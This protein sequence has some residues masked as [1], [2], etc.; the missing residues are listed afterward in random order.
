MVIGIDGHRQGGVAPA[1]DEAFPS[2]A[3][4]R[5]KAVGN[6][7]TT[8]VVDEVLYGVSQEPP[9][10]DDHPRDIRRD[11]VDTS[12][13]LVDS[14]SRR[15]S[16]VHQAPMDI[17]RDDADW[18]R[19]FAELAAAVDPE[20]SNAGVAAEVVAQC[21]RVP[22]GM[23]KLIKVLVGAAARRLVDAGPRRPETVRSHLVDAAIHADIAW[24]AT[25]G[26]LA[27]CPSWA[28]HR[29][30]TPERVILTELRRYLPRTAA[31]PAEAASLSLPEPVAELLV[32]LLD[33]G[34][35]PSAAQRRVVE[36]V[37]GRLHRVK[38]D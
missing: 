37:R 28:D 5:D 9:A 29:A 26:E 22:S 27:R 23:D 7:R 2:F 18:P 14:A 11:I 32:K 21:A 31:E 24:C 12:L 38:P 17:H 8:S 6:R 10:S 4:L 15:E 30:T 16:A 36:E 1:P 19:R 33:A 35:W 34:R 20:V 25:H 13:R 3:E